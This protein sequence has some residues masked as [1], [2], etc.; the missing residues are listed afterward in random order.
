M[1][2]LKNLLLIGLIASIALILNGCCMTKPNPEYEGGNFTFGPEFSYRSSSYW[3]KDAKEDDIKRV[4]GIG[5]GVYG[6]WVFCPDLPQLG[7]YSGLFYQQ[8]GARFDYEGTTD[9]TLKNKLHY[10]TI[11]ITWTYEVYDGIRVEVGPD[12]SFLLA[13]KEKYKY[14]GQ[15]ETYN[16]KDDISKVQVGFNV[17]ASYTHEPT[18]LAGFFRYNAGLTNV[19]SSDY[20]YVAKNGAISFGIR[21][22]L[23]QHVIK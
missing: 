23:N 2:H 4:G 5:L 12:L 10:L 16:I 3:G 9:E 21:Y 17:A 1:K 22:R 13:A 15:T 14:Q 6:H 18:G 8:H 19:P 11:P 7:F 20:D